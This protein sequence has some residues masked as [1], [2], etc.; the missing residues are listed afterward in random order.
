MFE[1]GQVWVAINEPESEL[2][3]RL[4][5]ILYLPER[6]QVIMR[7]VTETGEL[8]KNRVLFA[9]NK[10]ELIAGYRK[11]EMTIAVPPSWMVYGTPEEAE[12]QESIDQ[13]A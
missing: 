8:R 3:E 5:V 2:Q 11:D 6:F 13:L 4:V 10:E 7:P 9:V 12:G 1:T